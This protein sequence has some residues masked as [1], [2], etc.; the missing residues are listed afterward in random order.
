MVCGVRPACMTASPSVCVRGFVDEGSVFVRCDQEVVAVL[1]SGPFERKSGSGKWGMSKTRG[2]L[3]GGLDQASE[4]FAQDCSQKTPKG[5]ASLTN[6]R[7]H[8]T[9]RLCA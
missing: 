3:Y 8:D 2:G 7:R 5:L 1:S 4:Q 9:W 6:D